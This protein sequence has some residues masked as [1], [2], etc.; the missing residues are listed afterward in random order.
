MMYANDHKSSVD[1]LLNVRRMFLNG[2]MTLL[3]IPSM[4]LTTPL[5]LLHAPFLI[6]KNPQ[7]LMTLHYRGLKDMPRTWGT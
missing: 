3:T 2:P 1:V 6:F 5:T 7:T 4:L